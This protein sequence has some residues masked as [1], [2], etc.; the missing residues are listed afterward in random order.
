[1]LPRHSLAHTCRSQSSSHRH[2]LTAGHRCPKKRL[3]KHTLIVAASLAAAL[4]IGGVCGYFV[5]QPEVDNLSTNLA[6][7]QS[8]LNATTDALSRTTEE[9][10]SLE[11]ENAELSQQIDELKPTA[12]QGTSGLTVMERKTEVA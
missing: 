8:S 6:N 12:N 11:Q 2:H 9:K 3:S 7:T 4:L 1:M 5:R 10:H